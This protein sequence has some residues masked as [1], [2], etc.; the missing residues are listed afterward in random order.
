MGWEKGAIRSYM[1]LKSKEASFSDVVRI[2]F[3]NDIKIRKNFVDCPKDTRENFPPRW[4]IFVS[5]VAQKSLQIVSKPMAKVGTA[6]ERRLNLLSGNLKLC[7]FIF[8][9]DQ[10]LM[11]LHVSC[12]LSRSDYFTY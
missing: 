12:L 10:G 5:L 8:F 6:I 11:V 2:L 7:L 3:S 4:P 1:L 9:L